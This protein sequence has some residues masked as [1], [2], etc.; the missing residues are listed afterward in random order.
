[1]KTI[2]RL[3]C[4]SATVLLL[5][6]CQP[7]EETTPYSKP[8]YTLADLTS[9]RV[10]GGMEYTL[11]PD[12]K[13]KNSEL[14]IDSFT[15]YMELQSDSILLL[16]NYGVFPT[17]IKLYR[18][19]KNFTFKDETTQPTDWPYFESNTPGSNERIAIHYDQAYNTCTYYYYKHTAKPNTKGYDVVRI[20]Y[21]L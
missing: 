7:E 1:M 14:S 13:E 6:S 3:L 9:T 21:E 8:V 11:Y 20:Y 10:F 12:D 18:G 15:L 5:H 2:I 17:T 16:H 19:A 4:L